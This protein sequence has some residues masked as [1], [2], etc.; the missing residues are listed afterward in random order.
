MKIDNSFWLFL[1]LVAVSWLALTLYDNN[2]AVK[3]DNDK[4]KQDNIKQSAVI[5]RQSFQFNRFNQ[6]A[7]TA[8]RNGIQADAKAQ[9]KIIEYKTILKAESSCDSLVPQLVTDGLF[10]YTNE[11]RER[12]MRSNSI[13]VN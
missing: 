1:M 3:S 9:E 7:T 12:A 13:D 2:T 10:E 8:Y 11:L 5:A 6:I 4:L